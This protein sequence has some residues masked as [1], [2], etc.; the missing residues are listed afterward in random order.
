MKKLPFAGWNAGLR[1][2]G[3]GLTNTMPIAMRPMGL[4]MKAPMLKGTTLCDKTANFFD[5]IIDMREQ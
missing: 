3:R 2:H 1:E 4:F 5:T